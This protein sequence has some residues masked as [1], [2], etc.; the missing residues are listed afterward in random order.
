[1]TALANIADQH[2]TAMLRFSL[3]DKEKRQFIAERYC[4]RG[5]IDDW[6]Y[7]SGP[8]DFTNIIKGYVCV[9]CWSLVLPGANAE[10]MIQ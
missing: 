1:M 3:D 10:P 4:F 5:S 8:D 2:Y 9:K 7:L 6:I